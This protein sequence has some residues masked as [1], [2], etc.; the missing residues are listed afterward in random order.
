MKQ[1]LLIL[2]GIL[3]FSSSSKA[4]KQTADANT[5]SD[6]KILVAY[7]SCTG[8]TEKVA[9]AIAKEVGGTIYRITPATAYTSADL[10]WNNKSS[11]SSVEIDRKSVV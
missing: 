9:N 8:T 4:Q 1:I 5:P 2:M 7:F 11:R 10:D 6:K 3:T